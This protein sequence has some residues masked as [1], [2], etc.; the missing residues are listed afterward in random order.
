M[1]R[2]A[3]VDGQPIW[4]QGLIRVL[5]RTP[6][7][8]VVGEA[9]NAA[10]LISR[11]QEFEPDVVLMDLTLDGK[12]AIEETATLRKMYPKVKVVVITLCDSRDCL[13]RAMEAGAAGYLLK[14]SGISQVVDSVR[15]AASGGAAFSP[16]MAAK[17]TTAFLGGDRTDIGSIESSL[18]F[19]EKEIL[20]LA[21]RDATNREIAQQCCI[22]ETTVKAHFRNIAQKLHTRH[23]SGA[24]AVAVGKGLLEGFP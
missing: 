24:V 23:R 15:L 4:R 7:F 14:A 9:E 12:D 21:A 13:V 3:V 1:V 5:E 8:E 2:L 20:L 6:G 17:L 18:S 22:S 16:V 11:A 10:E 19:R